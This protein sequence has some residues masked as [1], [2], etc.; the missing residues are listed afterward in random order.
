MARIEDQAIAWEEKQ[1]LRELQKQQL[2]AQMGVLPQAL[3]SYP[4]V[5]SSTPTAPQKA[6]TLVPSSSPVSGAGRTDTR[7]VVKQF[8]DWLVAEQPLEDQDDYLYAAEVAVDQKWTVEDL[9][10]MALP[11]NDL[12]KVAVSNFKLKDGIVRHLRKDLHQF[13]TIYREAAMLAGLG[14]N[15]SPEAEVI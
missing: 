8:F 13:K 15:R 3:P 10:E 2:L 4:G 14:G 12:Y 5:R 11:S 6:V 1:E 9:R 7:A